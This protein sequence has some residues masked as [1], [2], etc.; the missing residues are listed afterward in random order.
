MTTKNPWRGL[1]SYEEPQG[2]SNDYLFCGRDEETLEV[3]RLI[4]NNLFITMYSPDGVVAYDPIT[5]AVEIMENTDEPGLLRLVDP[6]KGY[7][8]DFGDKNYTTTYFE[9][10]A[11]DPDAVYIPMQ[12]TGVDDGDGM[13]YLG[14]YGAYMMQKYDFETLKKYG[15]YGTLVDGI[16]TLPSFEVKDDDGNVKYTFQGIFSQGSSSWYAG[17]N[18]E[19]KL[20]LPSAVSGKSRQKAMDV[21]KG[22]AFAKR[23]NKYNNAMSTKQLRNKCAKMLVDRSMKLEK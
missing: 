22:L 23:L 2:T 3:V 1:A 10:N 20:V 6:Y 17:K 14:S 9:V 16:I 8:E 13:T 19:F 5:Y 11:T 12:E 15:Y 21:A 7:A 18:T 4:D